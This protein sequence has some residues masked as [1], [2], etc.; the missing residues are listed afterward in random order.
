MRYHFTL[1]RITINNN[2]NKT[3]IGK[4]VE[5]L[6]WGRNSSQMGWYIG[7]VFSPLPQL[8]T[9]SRFL[10]FRTSTAPDYPTILYFHTTWKSLLLCLYFR[11][12]LQLEK[13]VWR[14]CPGLMNSLYCPLIRW[15]PHI[16]WNHALKMK[17]YEEVWNFVT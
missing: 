6:A 17:P 15:K 14:N 2:N 11:I 4:D 5:K 12:T 16:L 8:F 9:S 1:I 7:P 10:V 13:A 3:I